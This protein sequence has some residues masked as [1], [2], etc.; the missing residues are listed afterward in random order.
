M[1]TTSTLIHSIIASAIFECVLTAKTYVIVLYNRTILPGLAVYIGTNAAK[2][3]MPVS[4]I[5]RKKYT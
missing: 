2:L 4:S 1:L 5:I 3:G